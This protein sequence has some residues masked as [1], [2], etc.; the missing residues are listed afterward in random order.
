MSFVILSVVIAV[1][2]AILNISLLIVYIKDPLKCFRNSA[3]YLVMNLAISDCATCSI[4]LFLRL[5]LLLFGKNPIFEFFLHCL[6]TASCL[7]IAS[8]SIN[9]FLMVA[10]PIKHRILIKGRFMILWISA[11]WIISSLPF[12]FIFD[13]K[14]DEDKIYYG[15][16]VFAFNVVIVLVSAVMYSLTYYQLKKQSRNICSLQNSSEC[17]AQEIRI[18]KEKRFLNTV[19]IIACVALFCLVP[20]IALFPFHM[21][22]PSKNLI[23]G[24]LVCVLYLNFAINPLIYVI[25]L[26]NYRKSY[27]LLYC[28][29][30]S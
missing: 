18:R 25:R 12:V 9:R 13:G 14:H 2:G 3:T 11:I 5:F 20:T 26:P 16:A 22:L 19:V 30:A 27:L 10:Y 7:S 23:F 15:Y 1:A 8:I 24:I 6:M 4:F 28:R 17:R 21:H 29:R